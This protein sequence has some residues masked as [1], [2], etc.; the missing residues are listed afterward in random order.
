MDLRNIIIREA[1]RQ[2]VSLWDLAK[3]AT[4]SHRTTVFRYLKGE[5]DA[6][7]RVVEELLTVLG[8][9]IESSSRKSGG[10]TPRHK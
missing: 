8:L 1:E 3:R 6:R 5:T 10:E 9:R 4:A 2:G 7:S